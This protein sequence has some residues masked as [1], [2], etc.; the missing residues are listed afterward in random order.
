MKQGISLLRL[1]GGSFRYPGGE[2]LLDI[3][4]QARPLSGFSA[5]LIDGDFASVK[6][7]S[8]KI[9]IAMLEKLR[10]CSY[11][12]LRKYPVICSLPRNREGIGY[13]TI[14][15]GRYSAVYVPEQIRSKIENAS[16]RQWIKNHPAVLFI[17]L[18]T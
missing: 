3:P 18:H 9:P 2:Q 16:G 14:S 12:L 11:R 10:K 1:N 5:P 17:V 6:P 13:Q 15:S 7:W 4:P 8:D